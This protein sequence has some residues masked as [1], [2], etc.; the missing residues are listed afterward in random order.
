MALF[1]RKTQQAIDEAK[2]A[3]DR[4]DEKGI[5]RALKK[6]VRDGT[7]EDRATFASIFSKAIDARN[8][9]V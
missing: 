8:G 5:E 9:R 7:T 3:R 1:S 6:A 2:S 4:S